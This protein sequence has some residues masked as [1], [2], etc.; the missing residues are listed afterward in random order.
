[1]LKL[2]D[3]LILLQKGIFSQEKRPLF[4]GKTFLSLSSKFEM[5]DIPEIMIW[6]APLDCRGTEYPLLYSDLADENAADRG[7]GVV[8]YLPVSYIEVGIKGRGDHSRKRRDYRS[9]I[10]KVIIS[11][12]PPLRRS[13]EPGSHAWLF[14]RH[15]KR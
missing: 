2:S 11:R 8:E 1:V 10:K 7:S 3:R 6:Q 9:N 13:A 14:E 4:V 5:G 12:T 15:P